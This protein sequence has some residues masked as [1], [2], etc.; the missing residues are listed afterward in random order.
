MATY[1]ELF[2]YIS[3]PEY[4]DLVNRIAVA[5]AVKAEDIATSASPTAE[6]IAWAVSAL[7]APRSK[8]DAIINFVIAANSGLTIAQINSANDAA[9]QANVNTAVDK[10]F[11]V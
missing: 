2:D 9:V 7:T 8:A 1:Q 10:L 6:E 5:V 4:Q 3:T 11:G